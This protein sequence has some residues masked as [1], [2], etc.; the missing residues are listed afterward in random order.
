M[1]TQ[2]TPPAAGAGLHPLI[3]GSGWDST[4]NAKLPVDT[5]ALKL[6]LKPNSSELETWT[7][8][9]AGNENRPQNEISWYLAF[10]FCAWDGGRIPTLNELYYAAAGGSEQRKYPWGID[11][12]NFSFAS[13]YCLGDGID[14]CSVNDFT[15]VGSFPSGNGK[16]GHADL[17]G[18]VAEWTLDTWLYEYPN[19]CVDC[20][21]L[22]GGTEKLLLGG[23]Y[24]SYVPS[25]LGAGSAIL[26]IPEGAG[27]AYGVRC[28]RSVL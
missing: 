15:F 27:N 14:D 24:A 10:A 25:D 26:G 7:N 17:S 20:A 12:L 13:F 16:W 3:P 1:G 18:N 5:A 19:P 6:A 8:D 9:V 4:W 21:T 28:A 2:A 22:S 23:H 11:V